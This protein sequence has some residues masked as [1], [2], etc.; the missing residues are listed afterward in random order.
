MTTQ[1]MALFGATVE[2]L[3]TIQFPCPKTSDG[4]DETWEHV[5]RWC[6]RV[7]W[8]Y[9]WRRIARENNGGSVDAVQKTIHGALQRGKSQFT[10]PRKRTHIATPLV[11]VDTTL[12]SLRKSMCRAELRG[13]TTFTY[14]RVQWSDGTSG[15]RRGAL[16]L[17]VSLFPVKE[18]FWALDV[19]E[20]HVAL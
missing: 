2:N 4:Q 15:Q 3:Q 5:L 16:P 8:L 17:Q 20:V 1:R 12:F 7:M 18:R 10:C 11:E 14:R 19:D 9:K 6:S 13:G